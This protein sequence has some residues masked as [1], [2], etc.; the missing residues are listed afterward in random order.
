MTEYSYK[1]VAAPRRARKAKGIKGQEA[2]LAHAMGEII[3]AETAG[4]WEYIRTDSLPVEE[5]GGLFSRPVTTWRAILIFRRPVAARAAA[6]ASPAPAPREPF[7][8]AAAPQDDKPANQPPPVG[9]ARR[10]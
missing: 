9:G 4:G 1:T 7:L 6:P 5:G 3:T 8:R 2:L 10:E